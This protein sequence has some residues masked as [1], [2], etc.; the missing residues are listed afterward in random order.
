[1]PQRKAIEPVD[2]TSP[3]AWCDFV[4]AGTDVIGGEGLGVV[5]ATGSRT[6]FG[7]TASLVKG[8]RAAGDFQVNLQHFGGF[9]LRFGV[10]LAAV[11]F[12]SNALLARG[13]V[14]SL[15]LALAVALGIVPEALPAVTATTLALGASH[16]A[17]K[18]ILVRRLAAVE[19]LSAVDTLCIYKTGTITENR[20]ALTQVWSLCPR[21]AVIEA[22]VLA[23]S[24]PATGAS[25]V[26]DA[27]IQAAGNELDISG[28]AALPRRQVTR[29]RGE[30]KRITVSVQRNARRQLGVQGRRCRRAWLL[31]E[32]PDPRGRRGPG[33]APIMR[34]WCCSSSARAAGSGAGRG[35]VA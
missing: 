30:T 20:T 34:C 15:T 13:V 16:L 9:L 1:M 22:A 35:R 4:F 2:S 32:H 12:L 3:S 5:A 26:D 27:V 10:V 28:L 11:V 21:S 7:E 14:I 25:I 18:K 31:L 23:S 33:A 6:Q 19:D 24:Y 17:R 29:F 8:S